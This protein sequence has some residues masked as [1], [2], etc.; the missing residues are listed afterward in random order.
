MSRKEPQG[1]AATRVLVVD[2]DKMTA[3]TLTAVLRQ[4][5]FA[6]QALYSGEETLEWIEKNHP[7][8][9]LTDICMRKVSGIDTAVR[10]RE[11]HP[12][13]RILVFSASTL[14]ATQRDEIERLHLEFLE[15]PLHPRDLL[16]RLKKSAA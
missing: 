14:T 15:R 5:G 10:V 8:V 1:S 11:L 3:D 4:A 6:A 7:H 2:D 13:C 12:E 9:V 16:T